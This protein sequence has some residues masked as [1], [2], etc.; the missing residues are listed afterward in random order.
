MG[1]NYTEP[2][3]LMRRF[4]PTALSEP[5]VV[6]L[7]QTMLMR[8]PPEHTRLR[9]LVTKAFTARRIEQLHDRVAE[10]VGDL[11]E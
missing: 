10:I 5:A 6:E 2:E 8:D 1:K 3:A 11:L 4:G 7:A 9:G